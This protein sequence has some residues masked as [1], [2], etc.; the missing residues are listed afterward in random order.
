MTDAYYELVDADDPLGERFS[1]SDHV[2]S[3]WSA[4]M[5]NA[6]PVSALLVRA[7]E[8]YA[9]RP[10]TRLSRVVVDLLG[11]VP[12]TDQLWV[13]AHLRRPG[14]KIELLD[15][16]MLAPGPDGA[17]RPVAVASAWR[18]GH[19]DTD[20]L[21]FTPEAPLRPLAEGRPRF[22][23]DD[24][25][26]ATN[27][28]YIQSLDWRWLNDILN[29][30]PAECWAR[31]LVDLVV[32]EPLTPMQRLFTVAD[33]A[34]GMGSRL[35]VGEWLFLNTDL[36]VHIHRVPEGDWVGVRAETHY[37]SDGV[38]V[39]RGTLF[40]A[41]GSVAVLQQAQLVRRRLVIP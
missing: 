35:S 34:N 5:Q 22:P 1:A 12:V 25:N 14:A 15:A 41:L 30:I 32:G 4:D 36:V 18:F 6:A 29:S 13:R 7:L 8:R 11:P 26:Q 19:H 17:P 9:P 28:T 23:D 40:D 3:T 27:Q 20:E 39:S 31:P 10:D 2:I 38:G 16:E 33:I 21:F 24:V 37:G